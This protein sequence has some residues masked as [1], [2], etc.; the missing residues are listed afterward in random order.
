MCMCI[1]WGMEVPF[2]SAAAASAANELPAIWARERE[3]PGS[4]RDCA[5]SVAREVTG[6]WRN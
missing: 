3:L 2:H 4:C 6:T 1:Y 5:A